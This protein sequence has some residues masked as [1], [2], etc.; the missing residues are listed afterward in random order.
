M[1]GAVLAKGQIHGSGT[2]EQIFDRPEKAD[3]ADFL[4]SVL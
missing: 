3:T 1:P 4:R 2:P